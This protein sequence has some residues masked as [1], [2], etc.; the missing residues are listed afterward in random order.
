MV[1]PCL[2]GNYPNPALRVASSRRVD[3]AQY[4][5]RTHTLRTIHGAPA[6]PLPCPHRVTIGKLKLSL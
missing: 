4:M 6:L 5:Q 2:L 3:I 1:P